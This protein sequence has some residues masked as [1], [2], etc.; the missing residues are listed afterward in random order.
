MKKA[1][2]IWFLAILALPGCA[3]VTL[4][5][6]DFSW[7]FESVLTADSAGYVR[8]EPKTIAFNA[9][10]LF[11]AEMK[12]PAAAAGMV[13]RI[14]RDYDGYYF[15]TAPG[16]RNVYIFNGAKG[17][18]TLRKKVLIAEQGMEKPFFNRRE[19]GIEL[20]ANGQVYLLSRKGIVSGGKK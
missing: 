19:L 1:A 15:I 17:K 20:V 10:E 14:I 18:L 13:V 7:A 11:R 5:P 6:V 16:F 3:S 2:L 4:K 8:A 12:D 9:G